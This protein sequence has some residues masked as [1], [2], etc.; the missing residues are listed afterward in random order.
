MGYMYTYIYIIHIYIYILYT[1]IYI[2]HTYIYIYYIHIYVYDSMVTN[3]LIWRINQFVFRIV[4]M[5][6]GIPNMQ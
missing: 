6:P 4:R 5:V 3:W 2:L 1:H